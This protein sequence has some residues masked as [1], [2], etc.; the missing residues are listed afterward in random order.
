MR[1]KRMKWFI[2]SLFI[3]IVLF[4][5]FQKWG[6]SLRPAAETLSQQE[7]QQLVEAQYKG[8]VTNITL[9]D[10]RYM[11]ELTKNGILYEIKL[12]AQLGEVVSFSKIENLPEKNLSKQEPAN[13][14]ELTE[15][16]IKSAILSKTPG[17]LL[18]FK[19][20]NEKGRSF[21]EG[22]VLEND[23]KT[24]LKVDAIT[25]DILSRKVEKHKKSVTKISEKEAGEIA[26]KE[27]KGTI[28]DIELED[29]DNLLFYLVEIETPDDREATVQIDAITG[30]I[31]TISWDD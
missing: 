22:I 6:S 31:L 20:I 8:K 7:A 12:D 11:I 16:E 9:K 23:Q 24:I 25:G 28:H 1:N 14:I 2:I 18:S 10:K 4:I 17:E 15:A 27:I 21:Y 5:G 29:E 26:L 13:L 3:G 19:K 30:A